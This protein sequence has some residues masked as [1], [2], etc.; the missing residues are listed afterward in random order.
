VRS[1]QARKCAEKRDRAAAA[2]AQVESNLA[3][4]FTQLSGLLSQFLSR[5]A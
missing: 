1:R 2:V 4:I 3:A 5:D